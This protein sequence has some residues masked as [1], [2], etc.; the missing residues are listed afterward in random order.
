M[1]KIT[2]IDGPV[3]VPAGYLF[4]LSDAQASARAHVLTRESEGVYRS[5]ASTQWKTGET[6]ETDAELG[7]PVAVRVE[8]EPKAKAKPKATSKEA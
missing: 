8:A 1:R 3:S 5:T 2:V 6:F 7:K 4:A